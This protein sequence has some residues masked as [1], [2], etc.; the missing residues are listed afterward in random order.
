MDLKVL[1]VLLLYY[2]MLAMFFLA[3]GTYLTDSGSGLNGT[4]NS[5][6]ITADELDKGGL[7]GTGVD[8]GRF[9]GLITIGVG[10]PSDTPTIFSGIFI[11][12]QS[13]ILIFTI[14]FIV[15]SIWNG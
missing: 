10:L 12:I 2:S 8:F 9:I 11:F 6:N 1:A 3:G 7:F 5:G 15:S 4:L 14:G 13:S